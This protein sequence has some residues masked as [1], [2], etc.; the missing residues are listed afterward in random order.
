MMVTDL[1]RSSDNKT[2]ESVD[3]LASFIEVGGVTVFAKTNLH[4][5]CTHQ[6]N[7]RGVDDFN[8]RHFCDVANLAAN[9]H[10]FRV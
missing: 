3:Q 2:G 8:G 9:I 5:R 10:E 7:R 6:V 1:W 4:G